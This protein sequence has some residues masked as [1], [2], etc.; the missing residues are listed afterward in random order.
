MPAILP[1]KD[2]KGCNGDPQLI[3]RVDDTRDIIQKR[4]DM[5][6]DTT[7]LMLKQYESEGLLLNFEVIEGVKDITRLESAILSFLEKKYGMGFD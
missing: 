5:H 6:E 7:R 2:C 3:K 1:R 4:L